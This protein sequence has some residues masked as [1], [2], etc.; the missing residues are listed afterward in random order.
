VDRAGQD[1]LSGPALPVQENRGVVVADPGDQ[2][3]DLLHPG[4]SPY[5]VLEAVI[6]G[7]LRPQVENLFEEILFLDHAFDEGKDLVGVERLGDVVG[8]SQLDRFDG[9]FQRLHRRDDH[10]LCLLV[11]ILD[12]A[13]HLHPVHPRHADV[14]E[15][16]IHLAGAENAQRVGALGGEEDVIIIGENRLEGLQDSRIVVNDQN[17]GL[18]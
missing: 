10:H 5:E 12:P 17:G 11:E 7:D 6:P 1:F 9:G 18:T 8:G 13:E 14:Q 15:D 3:V 4:V 16:E 2:I